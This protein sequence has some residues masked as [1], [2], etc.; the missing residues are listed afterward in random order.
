MTELIYTSKGNLPVA[1]LTRKVDWQ[2]SPTQIT[3]VEKYFD[4]TGD[5]VKQGSD[6]FILPSNMSIQLLEGNLNG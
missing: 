4:T 2:F 6:V 1:E 5:V 3:L